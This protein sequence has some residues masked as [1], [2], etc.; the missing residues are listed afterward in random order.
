MVRYG[1]AWL[2]CG[3]TNRPTASRETS[4]CLYAIK[5]MIYINR[6]CNKSIAV[7]YIRRS[8]T[9]QCI[10]SSN[11]FVSDGTSLHILKELYKYITAYKNIKQACVYVGACVPVFFN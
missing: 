8:V 4:V 10:S 7:L 3:K 1:A 2:P 6:K 5:C 11:I 9:V